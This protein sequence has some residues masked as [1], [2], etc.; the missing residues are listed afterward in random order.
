M[1]YFLNEWTAFIGKIYTVI[2]SNTNNLILLFIS[3]Y[4]KIKVLCYNN[5]SY[6]FTKINYKNFFTKIFYLVKIK[7][8]LNI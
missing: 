8:L 7:L 6:K 1:H 3:T 4:L 5:L 2:Q